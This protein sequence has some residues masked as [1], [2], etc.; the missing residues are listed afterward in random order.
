VLLS[1][2]SAKENQMR[3]FIYSAAACILA[4]TTATV[5]IA[6]T[7][8]QLPPNCHYHADGRVHCVFKPST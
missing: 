6:Q 2:L 7:R 4:G 3:K 5:V 8:P 1:R